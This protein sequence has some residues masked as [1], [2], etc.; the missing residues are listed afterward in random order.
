MPETAFFTIFCTMHPDHNASVDLQ[1]R[2]R[3]LKFTVMFTKRSAPSETNPP[4]PILQNSRH[5]RQKQATT[6]RSGHNGSAALDLPDLTEYLAPQNVMEVKK[7]HRAHE[8]T[9][10]NIMS[11]THDLFKPAISLL[12]TIPLFMTVSAA[13]I[14]MQEGTITDTWMRLA[15]GYMAQAVA[16]QYLVYGSQR[17]E[18]L[19]EAFSWGFDPECSAE[20]GTDDFQINAMFWGVDTVVGGWDRIRD[21]HTQAVGRKPNLLCT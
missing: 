10:G 4:R 3:L 17:Q 16:E 8:S 2:L 7:E 5:R 19:Q 11:E 12:D 9:A 20:E 1:F 15:A 18:V 14:A 13:Q 6:F 21:E